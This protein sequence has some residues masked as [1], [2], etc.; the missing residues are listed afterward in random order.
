MKRKDL[1]AKK[2]AQLMKMMLN[3]KQF[4]WNRLAE[5]LETQMY[6]NGTH[7]RFRM[8][9]HEDSSDIPRSG[10]I[11]GYQGF[12]TDGREIY[13]VRIDNSDVDLVA[14]IYIYDVIEDEG[15]AE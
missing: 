1:H 5:A 14:P 6:P 9:E 3:D 11:K 10:I 12:T 15:E 13:E 2:R 7:V 8:H 4:N